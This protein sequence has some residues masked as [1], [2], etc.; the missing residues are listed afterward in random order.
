[1][2]AKVDV[3]KAV[4]VAYFGVAHARIFVVAFVDAAAL[5]EHFVDKLAA[6]LMKGEMDVDQVEEEEL[7]KVSTVM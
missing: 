1:M 7:L 2:V 4:I 6:D 5:A 3:L